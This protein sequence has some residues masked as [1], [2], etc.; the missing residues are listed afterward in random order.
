M[1]T[2]LAIFSGIL[3]TG[4]PLASIVTTARNKWK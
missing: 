1:I 3:I 4:L 2:A